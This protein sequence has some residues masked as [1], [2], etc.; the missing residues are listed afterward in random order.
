MDEPFA[1]VDAQTR[2]TLQDELMRIW[3]KTHKTILF[4][5]HSIDEAVILADRVVVMSSNPGNIRT[6]IDIGLSRP[7]TNQEIR[8][9]PAFAEIRQ[10]VWENLQGLPEKSAAA[11]K[12][13]DEA[14]AEAVEES[15]REAPT[16]GALEIP[17]PRAEAEGELLARQA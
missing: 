10:T 12:G 17:Y 6:I 7:R 1:A 14:E 15:E 3:E 2:E 9:S 5:T 16:G 4:V 8:V 11:F 13:E